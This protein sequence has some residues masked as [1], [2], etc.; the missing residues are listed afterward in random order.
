[1]PNGFKKLPKVHTTFAG[2]TKQMCSR[3]V[4]YAICSELSVKNVDKTTDC[5]QWNPSKYEER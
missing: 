3:C 2:K 1:M 4:G 5:C